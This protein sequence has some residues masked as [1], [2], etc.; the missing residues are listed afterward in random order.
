VRDLLLSVSPP[1]VQEAAARLDAAELRRA[2][3]CRTVRAAATR[4]PAASAPR[5]TA[6]RHRATG[7]ART[8]C[9]RPRRSRHPSAPRRR[10]R[11]PRPIRSAPPRTA[12][13]FARRLAPSS[14][15]SPSRTTAGS[16]GRSI[17]FSFSPR[18]AT[19]A[20]RP[21]PSGTSAC[22]ACRRAQDSARPGRRSARMARSWPSATRTA[23]SAS[24]APAG[25]SAQPRS[26]RQRQTRAFPAPS[27]GITRLGDDTFSLLTRID[28][29]RST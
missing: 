24:E 27:A 20:R 18:T 16:L 11:P 22:T 9:R 6:C 12:T 28:K 2:A 14:R 1:R 26:Q 3:A 29:P 19:S 15:C 13:G 17:G 8:G 25:S 4:A 23:T 5:P 10:S 21:S 7:T